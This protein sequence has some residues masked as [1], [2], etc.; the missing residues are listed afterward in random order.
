LKRTWE[1]LLHRLRVSFG[2]S[3][4]PGTG[5]DGHP[6]PELL[7]AYHDDQLSPETDGEIQEHFVECEEC[8]ELMLD[9]DQLTTPEAVEAA[10]ADLPDTW[11]DTAWRRLRSGL[12][13]EARPAR[14]SSRWLRSPAF[15]WALT[16]LLV[17]C[18]LFLWFR[19]D[20]LAGELRDL[21]APQLNPPSWSVEPAPVLR[22]EDPPPPELAVP[23]GVRRFSLVFNPAGVPPD[24]EY[25]LKIRDGQGKDI[26]SE[27]GL[28]KN[29]EGGFSVILSRRFLP[30][31]LYIFQVIGLAGEPFE[32]EFPLRLTYL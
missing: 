10:K 31:G 3:G 4:R 22:S 23:A 30:A 17:P 19:V 11:V 12:A 21:Q 16:V 18:T 6:T 8:P 28:Y 13:A 15:A 5:A 7:S 27:R 26:W 2:G 1:A 29:A 25:R 9:L 32:E 24:L 14:P 20:A